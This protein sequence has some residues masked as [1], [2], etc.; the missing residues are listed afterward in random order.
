MHLDEI[1]FS[2][3]LQWIWKKI[4][5]VE[6]EMPFDLGALTPNSLKK[7]VTATVAYNSKL[8]RWII[9]PW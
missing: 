3:I 7:E 2:I 5:H 4:V 9:A 1:N 8:L 6:V